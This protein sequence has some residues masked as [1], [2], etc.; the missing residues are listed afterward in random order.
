[1]GFFRKD[2]KTQV[3]SVKLADKETLV[4]HTLELQ[5]D[6]LRIIAH[7]KSIRTLK[8]SQITDLAHTMSIE[9][10]SSDKSPIGRAVAGGLLLGG[11]GAIVG[12]ASGIGQKTSKASRFHLIIAY[13]ASDGKD[14][15]LAFTD[16]SIINKS[17]AFYRQLKRIV[18][19]NAE[20][21]ITS[22]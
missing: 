6:H 4:T 21:K 5:Q 7:D 18:D 2:T 9:T 19:G 16:Y 13:Q 8:F 11:I 15:L 10:L 3:P 14:K 20:G 22:L 17:S 1:M 12:A